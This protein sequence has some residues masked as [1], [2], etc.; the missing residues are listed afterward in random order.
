M[1]N[2]AFRVDGLKELNAMLQQLPLRVEK[3]IMRTAIGAASRV[4]RDKAKELAP[5]DSGQLRRSIR[6]GS[7][8]VRRGKAQVAVTAAA[9]Y[10]RFLEFGTAS[11]YI[12]SG[13]TVGKPYSIPKRSRTGKVSRKKKALSFNGGDVAVNNV[14]HPGVRPQPFMRPAF[15]QSTGPAIEAFRQHVIARLAKEVGKL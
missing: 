15:D 10:A 3:N 12:G 6:S 2:E 4:V 9:W 14:L 8:R 5:A 13:K 7:T 11:F 1:A